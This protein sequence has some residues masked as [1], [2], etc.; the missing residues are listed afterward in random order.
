MAQFCMWFHCLFVWEGVWKF[1]ETHLLWGIKGVIFFFF[2]LNTK[3]ASK[4]SQSWTPIDATCD[5]V[6]FIVS[7]EHG[8]F[9]CPIIM[10][11]ELWMWECCCVSVYLSFW[12]HCHSLVGNITGGL[13][14]RADSTKTV[15]IIAFMKSQAKKC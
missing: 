14:K 2:N 12:V 15:V 5:C 4:F 10:I 7:V 13:L 6:F 8:I 1:S 9:F 11:D 3:Q